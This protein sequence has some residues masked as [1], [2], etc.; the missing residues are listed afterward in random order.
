[1]EAPYT[2]SCSLACGMW[3]VARQSHVVA[4]AS[5]G[6]TSANT[7]QEIKNPAQGKAA[8]IRTWAQSPW[9]GGCLRSGWAP[10][11]PE[12]KPPSSLLIFNYACPC[13]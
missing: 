2:S 3:H 5:H 12:I 8:S 13:V 1:M 10:P 9:A 11:G 7:R 4:R 6:A